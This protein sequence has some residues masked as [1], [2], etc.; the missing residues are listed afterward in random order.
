MLV[1]VNKRNDHATISLS[2]VEARHL[3][4]L[5]DFIANTE[6]SKLNN[7]DRTLLAKL[8]PKL[9]VVSA[10]GELIS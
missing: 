7:L 6:R 1:T 10:I 4:D 9:A 3:F 8:L 5:L 2:M